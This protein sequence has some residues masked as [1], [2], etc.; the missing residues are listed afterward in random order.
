MERLES[1]WLCFRRIGQNLWF[2]NSTGWIQCEV[3][4]TLPILSSWIRY[5]LGADPRKS[6]MTDPLEKLFRSPSEHLEHH[7][8][9]KLKTPPEKTAWFLHP[10]EKQTPNGSQYPPLEQT[11]PIGFNYTPARADTPP[12]CTHAW[13]ELDPPSEHGCQIPCL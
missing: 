2:M 9:R 3:L 13:P 4:T 6:E 7:W 8:S 10:P 1:N 12:Q 11:P 5:P